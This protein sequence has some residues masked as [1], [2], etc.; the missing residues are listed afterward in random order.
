M[1]P[2]KQ[3]AC[4]ACGAV[5][6][7]ASAPTHEKPV[8]SGRPTLR[9][10]RSPATLNDGPYGPP[11]ARAGAGLATPGDQTS[12]DQTMPSLVGPTP[13]QIRSHRANSTLL[14]HQSPAVVGAGATAQSVPSSR[15]PVSPAPISNG[16]APHSR[17]GAGV[18]P[19]RPAL[20][21]VTAR[22]GPSHNATLLGHAPLGEH[23]P[24]SS[25]RSSTSQTMPSMQ[26]VRNDA[27]AIPTAPSNCDD[28]D[29]DPFGARVVQPVE[30]QRITPHDSPTRTYFAVNA[31]EVPA[32][33]SE[34]APAPPTSRPRPLPYP[35]LATP[36]PVPS[37]R[38]TDA[39]KTKR[40]D[41]RPSN[42]KPRSRASAAP[43]RASDRE[44]ADSNPKAGVSQRA[45]QSRLGRSVLGLTAAL[46]VGLLLFSLLWRPAFPVTV[47]INAHE[48]SPSLEIYCE[49]CADGSQVQLD[50]QRGEFRDMRASL[51]LRT[52]PRVG[53]NTFT[54]EVFRTGLGRD[55]NVEV[56]A[57][58]DYR[59]HWALE[60]LLDVQPHVDVLVETAPGVAVGVDDDTV[61]LVNNHGVHPVVL[62][63]SI[64]GSS[65]S[66]EW[67][68]RDVALH[69][70]KPNGPT[71]SQRFG[72][73]LPVVPL[74]IDTPWTSFR[75]DA[76]SVVVGGRTLPG[77][78][79]AGA[80]ART[81]ADESGYFELRV[82]ARPG[83]NQ[84][85]LVASLAEHMPRS[86]TTTFVQVPNLTPTA[87]S[88]Q[89][90]AVRRFDRL[91]EQLEATPTVSVALAGKVQEWKTSHNLTV[92]LVAVSAGCPVRSCLV[93]VEYPAAAEFAA[94]EPISVFGEA[95]PPAEG[96]GPLPEVQSH[97]ILR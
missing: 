91:T 19:S 64:S 44:R 62:P 6:P 14:G 83:E 97:F 71:A 77:A 45:R 30:D 25:S 73:R 66:V 13:D 78:A 88:Y 52:L 69:I 38:S 57:H 39:A 75:T 12:S 27:P 36:E 26:A 70:T 85:E 29:A 46:G 50:G 51:P 42:P 2:V 11:S 93:R 55:E 23:K 48:T 90:D 60:G 59:A 40:T 1:N 22:S 74:T 37:V 95:R 16:A 32:P 84:L 92:L 18:A 28:E 10:M 94:N 76:S 9:G 54:L 34:R 8:M 3:R 56:T 20:G 80:D 4:Q 31:A 7:Y 61:P 72:V 81:I 17:P 79:V 49:S 82:P 89:R 15:A 5:L 86:A 43:G 65:N 35:T 41:R 58:V 24:Y 67:L 87:V 21:A 47:Q 63:R 53:A 33:G 68:D 96:A